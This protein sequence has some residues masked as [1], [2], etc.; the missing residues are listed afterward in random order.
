M[1]IEKVLTFQMCIP[2]LEE[3]LMNIPSTLLIKTNERQYNTSVLR[4]MGFFCRIKNWNEM[5][6]NSSCLK[7]IHDE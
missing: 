7:W 1:H 3:M 2:A 5:F 4:E 6:R